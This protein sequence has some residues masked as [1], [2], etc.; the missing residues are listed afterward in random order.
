VPQARYR[1]LLAVDLGERRIG[2]AVSDPTGVLASALAVVHSH[3]RARDVQAVAETAQ[4]EGVE[5]VLVGVPVSMSGGRGPMAEKSHRFGELL[6]ERSGLPVVYWD[7]RLTTVEASR[8]LRDA[9][10]R[11]AKRRQ[12]LDAHAAAVLLQSYLDYVRSP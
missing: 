5:A 4:R 7:E 9:G 2:L 1:H 6:A 10:M 8:Y 11:A 12:T 3:G